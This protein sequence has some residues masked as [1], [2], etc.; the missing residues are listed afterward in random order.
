MSAS[1]ND[2]PEKLAELLAKLREV[3]P[4]GWKV[5]V[6]RDDRD[7][8][9]QVWR[10]EKVQFYRVIVPNGPPPSFDEP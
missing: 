9:I 8:D 1:E 7:F 5:S 2:D 3:T 10:E 6:T 4:V